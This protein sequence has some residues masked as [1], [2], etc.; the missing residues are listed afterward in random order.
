MTTTS[1]QTPA[2]PSYWNQA[3]GQAW[4]DLQGLMD[5]LN[6]P[7]ADA[8]IEAGFPGK[9]GCVL[10]IGCG[11]G[12]TTLDMA[13]RLGPAGASVGVD[14]SAPLLDAA[15]AAAQ[16]QGVAN[17]QFLEGDAQTFDLGTAAYDA[18]ISRFGVMFFADFDQAFA[19]LRRA[20]KPGGKLAFVCWRSPADNPLA[21]AP[22][23]AAA[24][25]LPPMP[26]PD[27]NAP[28]RWAFAD[29]ERVRGI[30]ARTGWRDIEIAPLDV[31]T[32]I[33]LPDLMTLSLRMGPLG[34][35]LQQ[36]DEATQAK[37]LAAMTD[38]LRACEVDG[39]VAMTAACW[40]VTARA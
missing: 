8:V 9:G 18:A 25:Y 4:V 16:A 13:R 24:P 32:P 33:A 10:D 3:G 36:A 27:L 21:G 5:G 22:A 30:L 2:Q 7:I 17:A 6:Q 20:L 14:V 15:R 26:Q 40:L 34:A 38:R 37:V 1:P 31:D 35:R 19:N 28:G 12:T 23:D 29:P 39:K 11:A